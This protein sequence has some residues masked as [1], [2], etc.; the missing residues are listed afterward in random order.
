MEKIFYRKW[1]YLVKKMSI[2]IM[3]QLTSY[4]ADIVED[5]HGKHFKML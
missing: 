4:L 2:Q 3:C 1:Q 5:V